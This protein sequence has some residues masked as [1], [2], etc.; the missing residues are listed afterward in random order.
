MDELNGVGERYEVSLRLAAG[1][2]ASECESERFWDHALEATLGPS[3][4]GS[5][6]G[7]NTQVSLA[8]VLAGRKS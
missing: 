3:V 7:N 1:R 5:V 6:R 8:A 4:R 2:R